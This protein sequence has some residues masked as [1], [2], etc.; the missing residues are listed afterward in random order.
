[1]CYAPCPVYEV[2][3]N[4]SG[5]ARFVG[6]YFVDMLGEY[7]AQIST[8]AFDDLAAAALNIGF[9]TMA[10][11]YA[12]DYTDASTTTTWIVRNGRRRTVED[13]GGAGPERLHEFEGLVDDAASRLR[14]RHVRL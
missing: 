4:R 9:A 6:E 12:V 1:M 2:T 5:E 7:E 14:W 3:L 13:Y 8:A 11:H 10:R